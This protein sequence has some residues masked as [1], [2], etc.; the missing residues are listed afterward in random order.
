MASLRQIRANRQ[1]STLS[2]GPSEIGKLSSRL[3]ALTHGMT[4]L[5][6][7]FEDDIE[8]I[9]TLMVEWQPDLRAEGPFQLHQVKRMA[10]ASLLVER[11]QHQEADWRYRQA[12]RTEAGR[13]LDLSVETEDLAATLPRRPARV[14]RRLQQTVH[15]NAWLLARLR[16]LK[17]LICGVDGNGPLRPLDEENAAWRSTSSEWP[18]NSAR[19]GPRSTCPPGR[20]APATATS[21]PTRPA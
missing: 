19:G 5:E 17:E 2:R 21:R 13:E 8:R 10:A 9:Q 3:N 6:V 12:S 18:P 4:A 20:R 15:G 16:V 1:N 7:G 14:A 11:C